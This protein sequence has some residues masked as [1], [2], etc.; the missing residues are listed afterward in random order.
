METTQ[1]ANAMD[2]HSY[3]ELV[4]AWLLTSGLRIF[5]IFILMLIATKAVNF[6]LRRFT[7][8]LKGRP[9][10][11][12]YQ[13]RADTLRSIMQTTLST[14]I[15]AVAFVMI[16]GELGIQI[17]PVIA[18]AGV[19]GLA[20]GFGAQ[21]LVEDVISGFFILLED[22][23]RVGDVVDIAGKAGFVEK[24][25]LRMVVLR[26]LAGSVHFVRNGQIQT[27]TNMT[28][29]FSYYVFDVG[30]AYREN[31]DEVMAVIREVDESM[32]ADEK[33]AKSILAP[34]EILGLDKF[35]DSAV[36]IKARTKTLPIHQWNVGRE[37]NKRLKQRFDEKGIEI[38]F[39]HVTLYMG[40]SKKGEAPPL[41]VVSDGLESGAGNPQITGKK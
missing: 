37:F 1:T 12:D 17:G 35:A 15:F 8:L 21:K 3:L 29:D 34:I 19:V 18:A 9:A 2:V 7:G 13:K 27:V 20:I 4:G 10:D 38:P 41:R 36:I 6:L 24:V 39:P 22:Q 5:L 23:I 26:D 32:R 11:V 31:V 25:T 16:L 40:E 28:K 33:Y 30:V 14:V